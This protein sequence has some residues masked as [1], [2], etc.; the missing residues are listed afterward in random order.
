M[1]P[2]FSQRNGQRMWMQ[3][4]G[5]KS[6]TFICRFDGFVERNRTLRRNKR[7]HHH[8]ISQHQSD[9]RQLIFL[10]ILDLLQNYANA[11]STL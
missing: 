9:L 1:R 2:T 7:S 5:T 3:E 8:L 11:T 6:E 10:R 4:I